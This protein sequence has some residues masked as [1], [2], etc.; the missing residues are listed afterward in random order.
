ME[1]GTI[2]PIMIRPQR[3][4]ADRTGFSLVEMMVVIAIIGILLGI[5]VP[6]ISARLRTLNIKDCAQKLAADIRHVR[7]SA[8]SEGRRGQ[9]VVTD[10]GTLKNFG[11][12][13]NALWMTFLDTY[14]ATGSFAAGDKVLSCSSCASDITIET[15]TGIPSLPAGTPGVIG[16]TNLS[17]WFSAIGTL[18]DTAIGTSII[19]TAASDRRYKARIFV[20]SLTGYVRVQNCTASGAVTCSNDGD[21][22]DI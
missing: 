4:I 9:L 22:H 19:I 20:T 8:M 21:W 7:A 18:K 12:G 11:N 3:A 14:P 17:M 1:K 2:D 5:A 16:A 10:N 13:Q 15:I 6:P